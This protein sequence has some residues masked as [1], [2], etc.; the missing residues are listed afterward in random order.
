MNQGG[1]SINLESG[2]QLAGDLQN[3]IDVRKAKVGDQV[4][5]EDYSGDQVGWAHGGELKVPDSSD[6]SPKSRRR[7]RQR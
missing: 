7:L 2:T 1:K 6:A 5:A 3:A 4:R